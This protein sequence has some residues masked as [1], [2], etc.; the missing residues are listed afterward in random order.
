MADDLAPMNIRE[1][2]EAMKILGP[3]AAHLQ[4]NL[5]GNLT[6]GD[7]IGSLLAD[8]GELNPVDILRLLALLH[9]KSLDEIAGEF[10]SKSGGDLVAELASAFIVNPLPDLVNA[11]YRLQLIGVEWD[12]G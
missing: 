1:A 4:G 3:Y 5:Q 11:G 8:A 7:A 9:H 12:H 2:V 10:S 6:L